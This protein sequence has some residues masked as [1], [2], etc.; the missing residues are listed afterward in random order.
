[1]HEVIGG[2]VEQSKSFFYT[3]KQAQLQETK[4]IKN[5]SINI[6]INRV[7]L[8]QLKSNET[9]YA[10][11]VYINPSLDWNDQYKVMKEKLEH[12]VTKLIR[13]LINEF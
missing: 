2:L 12:S 8:K 11:G 9:T 10:L 3:W 13:T 1:M 7:K 4:R 6:N 5:L